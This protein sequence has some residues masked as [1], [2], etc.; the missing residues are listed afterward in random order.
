[1]KRFILFILI[2]LFIFGVGSCEEYPSTTSELVISI[3]DDTLV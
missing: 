2:C 1:M 3:T